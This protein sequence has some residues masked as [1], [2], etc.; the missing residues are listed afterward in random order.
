MLKST[1]IPPKDC[2]S[3]ARMSVDPNQRILWWQER[4]KQENKALVRSIKEQRRKEASDAKAADPEKYARRKELAHRL[5]Q[6]ETA[7]NEERVARYKA[8]S[9]VR[10]LEA[11][12]KKADDFLKDP[13]VLAKD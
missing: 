1:D 12:A 11:V 13:I 8:E 10:E 3:T 7:L 9:D 2:P 6:A 5:K 4:I